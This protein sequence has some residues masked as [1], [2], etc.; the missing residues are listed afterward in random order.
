VS[1]PHVNILTVTIYN[2]DQ[3]SLKNFL[4]ENQG[5]LVELDVAVKDKFGKNLFDVIRQRSPTLRKLHLTTDRFID[6]T[7]RDEKVNWT[8]LRGMKQ[9]KDFQLARPSC[10]EPNWELYGTGPE[11]LKLLPRNQLERLGLRGIGTSRQLGFWRPNYG[12]PE[13]ELPL[14]LDLLRGFRNLRRLSLR[15]CTDAVDDNI[16]R[17]IVSEMTSLEELQV[18]HCSRLTDRGIVGT[19]EDDSDSIRNLKDSNNINIKY[20]SF[21][22]KFFR[23]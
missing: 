3:E 19:S 18:S 14:K 16:I 23:N 10:N 8:F 17:F 7:G 9:L 6:F 20:V 15:Y 13:P 22:S 11:L 1:L 12:E 5:S 2:K 4:I 21:N